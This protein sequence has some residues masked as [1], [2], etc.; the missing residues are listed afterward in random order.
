MP[1]RTT[2]AVLQWSSRLDNTRNGPGGRVLA[3]DRPSSVVLGRVY[4]ID[5][6]GQ[7]RQGECLVSDMHAA[8]IGL[9]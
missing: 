6:L 7:V 5:F 1:T 9:P 3:C 8:N 4:L 2:S